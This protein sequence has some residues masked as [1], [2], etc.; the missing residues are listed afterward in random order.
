MRRLISIPI[1]LVL[2][3]ILAG[4]NKQRFYDPNT[5][6]LRITPANAASVNHNI[7]SQEGIVIYPIGSAF[8][9]GSIL[10]P[11]EGTSYECLFY[12]EELGGEP[13]EHEMPIVYLAGFRHP[14]T[15]YTSPGQQVDM[16]SINGLDESLGLGDRLTIPMEQGIYKGGNDLI[17]DVQILSLKHSTPKNVGSERFQN[18][19]ADINIIIYSKAGDVIQI[20]YVN[21][22]IQPLVN[23]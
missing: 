9:W 20:I 22:V 21:G 4:C 8:V 11:D 23:G 13:E 10:G 18:A 15:E 2:A 12:R 17:K 19:D 7:I 1:I 6:V 3:L 16:I 5:K 14:G